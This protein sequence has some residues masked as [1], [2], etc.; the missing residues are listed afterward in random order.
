HKRSNVETSNMSK[1]ML[2]GDKVYSKLDSA[3]INEEILR[4][5]NHNQTVLNKAKH[6][7]NIVPKFMA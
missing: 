1:K 5:I 4:W 6:Q 3:R 2:H 7:W